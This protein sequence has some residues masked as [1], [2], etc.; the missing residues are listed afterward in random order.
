MV[1]Y[2]IIIEY[3]GTNFA[4]WQRQ[5]N[6]IS[7]QE[8]IEESIAQLTQEKVVVHAAGRTDAGVHALG[9][10]AHFS[11]SKEMPS[12][13]MQKG[14]NHFLARKGITITSC[15]FA[16]EDFHARFSAKKRSYRYIIL[17][18]EAPSALDHKRAWHIY[19]ALDLNKL[20]EAA[21]H[22]IGTHDFTSFRAKSCQAHSPIKTIDLINIYRHEDKIIFDLKAT[23]FLHHMVRNIVGS[24]VLV[25]LSKLE[26]SSIKNI[27]AAKD[28]SQA[29]PTAPP[30]GLYFTKVEY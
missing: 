5:S 29:G 19:K 4:G 23:S 9:Q 8:L 16:S 14:L 1:K 10:V 24:L 21:K 15:S 7:I 20:Q 3:E 22:L 28:R 30:H 11:V 25:G 26:S 13:L 6:A 27:L 18:R 12:N 17:N 2:Q